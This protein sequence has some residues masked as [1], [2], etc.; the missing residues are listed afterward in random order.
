[1]NPM[2]TVRPTLLN[3]CARAATAHEARFR[4][5][6]SPPPPRRTR[7]IALD[8]HAA[9]VV[10]HVAAGHVDDARFLAH[11]PDAPVTAAHS[12]ATDVVLTTPDGGSIRLHEDLDEADMIVLVASS[13]DGAL[14]ATAIGEAATRRGIMTSGLVLGGGR[15]A[16]AALHALR[17]HARVLLRSEREDD[18]PDVL[19]ALRA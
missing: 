4:M 8:E 12:D 5:P 16:S 15:S 14:A 18:L 6:G 9:E 1:M 11:H 13:D 3:S 2:S 19:T 7:I 10:R 17:P